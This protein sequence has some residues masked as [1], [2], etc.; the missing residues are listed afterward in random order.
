MIG[1]RAAVCPSTEW[2]QVN[3]LSA[4]VYRENIPNR[5]EPV[6]GQELPDG[7]FFSHYFLDQTHFL[8]SFARPSDTEVILI[9]A[10]VGTSSR[11]SSSHLS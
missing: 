7:A 1:G 5:N 6:G 3:D 2:R 11:L 10:A 9:S 4:A 8:S